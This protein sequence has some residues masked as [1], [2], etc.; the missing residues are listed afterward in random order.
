VAVRPST[1]P[2]PS[3][4]RLARLAPRTRLQ[5]MSRSRSAVQTAAAAHPMSAK[6][7]VVVSRVERRR[8]P[9]AVMLV[10]RVSTAR[11]AAAAW[12]VHPVSTKQLQPAA[13]EFH[14]FACDAVSGPSREPHISHTNRLPSYLKKICT[15][16]AK[17]RAERHIYLHTVHG[18]LSVPEPNG[19]SDSPPGAR[20]G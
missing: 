12:L 18:C 13:A 19:W 8:A 3:S 4:C 15:D 14:A 7:L 17:A 1:D 10:F 11:T 16:T 6:Q 9:S 2:R 5:G 20:L